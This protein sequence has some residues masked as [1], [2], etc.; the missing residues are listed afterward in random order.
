MSDNLL[1]PNPISGGGGKFEPTGETS[2]DLPGFTPVPGGTPAGRP[3]TMSQF[4]PQTDEKSLLHT[5]NTIVKGNVNAEFNSGATAVSDPYSCP[6]SE[7]EDQLVREAETR[8]NAMIAGIKEN[9][10]ESSWFGTRWWH[11]YELSNEQKVPLSEYVH[12]GG[13]PL[14]GSTY[15]NAYLMREIEDRYR[16]MSFAKENNDPAAFRKHCEEKNKINANTPIT[17]TLVM[18]NTNRMLAAAATGG[19]GGMKMGGSRA[20]RMAATSGRGAMRPSRRIEFVKKPAQ[21]APATTP[22][23]KPT[24]NTSPPTTAGEP[25][26]VATGEYLETW[27]DFLIPGTFPF[28]G[29]RYMGLK[30]GLP[31]RYKS[32]L[33]PC[34]ISMFDEIFSNPEHGKLIYHND[35]GKRI[36]FDRPFNFLPSINAGI[37]HLDLRAPWL[38]QLRLKDRSIIKHFRQY[39]DGVYRLESIEDL[40]GFKLTLSRTEDGRLMRADGPDGLSLTFDND[41]AG[42]RILITLIGTDG[43][44]KD[45]ARYSYDASGRMTEATCGFGMSVCYRW[46][47]GSNLLHSWHNL[48]RASETIFTY[49]ETGRVVHTKTNGIWNGDRFAYGEGETLYLPGGRNEHGQFFRYDEHQNVTAEVDPLGGTVAHDYN[50]AGFR[51]ATTDPNGNVTRTR[52]DTLGNVK[53]LTDPE[54]R[55]T[56]YGWGDDGE[57]MLVIDGAGNRRRYKHDDKANVI[58]ESDGE[59]NVTTLTRDTSGRVTETRFAN[60][61]TEYQTWDEH[62][63]LE[64]VTDAKGNVTRFAYDAFGRQIEVIAPNGATTRKAYCASAGGFET[65]SAITRPDGVTV[66]RSFDGAGELASVRDGEGRTWSYRY[67]AFAVLQAIIDPKGGELKIGTDIEGRVTSVTN[68][69]GRVYLFDRDLAGRVIAEEDFDGRVTRYRRDPAG[70]VIEAQKS[71]GAR[72]VYD[73]DKSGLLRRIESFSAKGAPQ[74]ITR[75][76]YDGRGLLV[77]AENGAALVSFERD[78]NGRITGETL[79]GRRVKSTLDVMGNRIA[80]EI[81]G[82]GHGL[83]GYIRD[84]LGAIEQLVAGDTEFSFRRDLFG[85]EIERQMGDFHLLQRFDPAGQLVAQAAGPARAGSLDVSRLGWNVPGGGGERSAKAKPGQIRRVYD[86]DRAFAPLSVDH[87]IWGKRSFAYDDNAQMTEAGSP[88]GSERFDYDPARNLVG[89]S[90]SRGDPDGGSGYGQAFDDTFGAVPPA[91]R[92]FSFQSTPGG[93]L[94]IARGPKGEKLRLTHDDCGRLIERRLDRD[95]F[96]PQTWRY[97]WDAHDRMVGVETPEGEEWLFHYDPFGR[98]VSKVRRFSS[99]E[100]Y[101][102]AF[103]WPSLVG[104]DG[105]PTVARPPSDDT[106]ALDNPPVVGTSYLWDG[107][108]MVAEAPLRLDGHVAW[109]E[110]TQWHFEEG[111]HRLLAKQLPTGEML[112]IVC[113]HL[114]TPKEMF[115]AKGTLVWAGDHHV[116]GAVRAVRTFGA[117]ALRRGPE[118]APAEYDCPWRFPGQYED[119]E[120]GLYYNRHRHYDPLAGQYASPDPIGL[121]GGDRPQGYVDDPGAW[122]DPLGL[123]ARPKYDRPEPTAS[124]NWNTARGQYWRDVGAI[125]AANPSGKYSP[126]NIDRMKKGRA[127]MINITVK[128]SRTGQTV[129]RDVPIELHHNSLTQRGGARRANEGWNLIQSTPWGHAAMDQYRHTGYDL[130]KINRGTNS[131]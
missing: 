21:P 50:R 14:G 26:S 20:P 7:F 92:P 10:N 88:S 56:V 42:R 31:T 87:S 18:E 13:F 80:R 30:L 96:R 115:D 65:V 116:W 63:R 118:T 57:L 114:G 117:L 121:A 106:G 44:T 25:V 54:G 95:G 15:K 79:N 83:V 108:H 16:L 105:I 81:K 72:L 23:T 123:K 84:P 78:R 8:Q 5:Y 104:E 3:F 67:G 37:P 100:R 126:A 17:E 125:E 99:A 38:K 32:P 74:D 22:A 64:S 39:E 60:G 35:T 86:Y 24:Q 68:A 124:K 19:R 52:Y 12:S 82:V 71:D 28:D 9:L 128:S 59:G 94:Q 120:T 91:P 2:Q 93:I 70:Q 51:T 75:F 58:S 107:D 127:P 4:R 62:N 113:D 131:W 98:R 66:S 130:V 55:S 109:D 110:A 61:A 111:T 36:W 73:Y 43:S 34:Q 49:D 53:E 119:A 46:L 112:S 76:W 85:Q 103:R 102:A 69:L 27:R 101:R 129:T 45:L 89:A 48:T 77:R 47:D 40:N 41:D 33:G 122:T 97:R 29:S 90:S 1:D 11:E 6:V